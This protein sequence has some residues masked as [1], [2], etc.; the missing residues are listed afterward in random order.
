MNHKMRLDMT[1]K[2]RVKF[3]SEPIEF[4]ILFRPKKRLSISVHPDMRVTVESPIGLSTEEILT[5]VKKKA[6]WIIKQ[7]EF[8]RQYMPRLP[9]KRY[10]SGETFYYLGRQY[11]LKIV[12]RSKDT[13][14]LIGRYI[15]V[16]T[17]DCSHTNKVKALVRKWYADHA[18]AVFERRLTACYE[19]A[20]RHK[21]PYPQIKLRRMS[22]R[23]GSC[24]RNTTILLNTELVKAP[25]HCIDYV[26][27]H[28]LCHLRFS[29]HGNRFSSLLSL[30]MPDWQQRKARLERAFV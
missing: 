3:G 11:R 1:N 4:S 22:K 28:E 25:V 16:Y 2:N 21:I 12:Q 27:V 30:L 24:G 9:D 26:I 23:W 13:V 10:V 18:R 5:E 6:R 29:K 15:W 17:R 14:K 20:K 8:F 7:R 19:R